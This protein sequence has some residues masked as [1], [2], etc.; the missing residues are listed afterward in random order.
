MEQGLTTCMATHLD[1]TCV[2]EVKEAGLK[3]LVHC[4]SG[5]YHLAFHANNEEPCPV[6][7]HKVDDMTW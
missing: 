4:D 7:L 1:A 2:T 5:N 3:L 6:I